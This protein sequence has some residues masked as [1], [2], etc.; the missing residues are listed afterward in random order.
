MNIFKK[1]VFAVAVASGVM[2]S[3]MAP[4]WALPSYE[5]CLEMQEI[6]HAGGDCTTFRRLCHV[7][8]LD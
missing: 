1:A 4:A 6:C 8:G 7:Y 2:V 3:A 5:T